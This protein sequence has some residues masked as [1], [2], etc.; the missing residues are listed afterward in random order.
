MLHMLSLQDVKLCLSKPKDNTKT[1]PKEKKVQLLL[2]IWEST[3]SKHETEA[4]LPGST[5]VSQGKRRKSGKKESGTAGFKMSQDATKQQLTTAAK[6]YSA[7]RQCGNSFITSFTF[8][9]PET[10]NTYE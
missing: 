9:T 5:P 7:Q 6:T 8:F 10:S 3:Q 4:P 1:R 2:E